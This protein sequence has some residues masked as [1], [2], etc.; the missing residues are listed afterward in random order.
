MYIYILY[1]CI[2]VLSVHTS[3]TSSFL[4]PYQTYSDRPTLNARPFGANVPAG[5]TGQLRAMEVMAYLMLEREPNWSLHC[6]A[7]ALADMH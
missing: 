6:C 2:K 4:F 7:A 3:L 5:P 1:I